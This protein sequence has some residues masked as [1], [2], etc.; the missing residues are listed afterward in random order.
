[1]DPSISMKMSAE[2]NIDQMLDFFESFLRAAGYQLDGK[3]LTLQE[4][5]PMVSFET[6]STEGNK[7][8]FWEDDGISMVGNPWM[9]TLGSR[10]SVIVGSGLFGA[11]DEDRLLFGPLF[12]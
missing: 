1:M 8:D 4:D 5:K 9:A 7:Y 11:E 6:A 2:A 12:G 3:S 10:D